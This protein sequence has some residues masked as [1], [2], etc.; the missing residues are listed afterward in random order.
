[1]KGNGDRGTVA[2]CLRLGV[3]LGRGRVL[4]RAD[5]RRMFS[6]SHKTAGRYMEEAERVLAAVWERGCNK[7]R[8]GSIRLVEVDNAR[9]R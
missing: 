7:Q 3:E 6:C 1:M 8:R 4:T 2:R 9:S 5:I